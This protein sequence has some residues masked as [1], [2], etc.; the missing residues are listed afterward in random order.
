MRRLTYADIDAAR[1]TRGQTVLLFLTDRCPVGC[2][3]C[4]VDSR[5]DS[6]KIRDFAR[7]EEVIDG[8]CASSYGL[9]GISGGEPFI[10]R[11]GL[12]H[13]TARLRAAGKDISIVT[14]GVWATTDDPPGWITEVLGRCGCVVLSTDIFHSDALPDERFVHA[15]RTIARAGVWVVTQV[16]EDPEAE[17]HAVDMLT[18]A[19][20]TGWTEYAEIRSA[21]LL[22]YGRAA[23]L[24]QPTA[25]TE[26][27]DF[28]PC[29]L[30]RSPVIR[31][32]GTMSVCCNEAVI[33]G[34]GPES[35]RRAC[36][37]ADDLGEAFA[38]L[39]R[40]ALFRAI[41]DAGPGVLTLD[42]RLSDMADRGY[43]SICEMCWEMAERV[44][45]A[46]DDPIFRAT[47][48]L[49]AETP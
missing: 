41:A 45:D 34:R 27:R 6:P 11:R 43:R 35:L 40:H 14:S 23:D 3:H 37:T 24:F 15:A 39:D 5:P 36:T 29:Y 49:T 10:E 7:F 16:I 20:G 42:P 33:M 47:S 46:A 22:P 8:L 12:S 30:A 32:D 44:G 21:P 28:G 9:V 25:T 31:Y 4:S 13:A 18:R 26:G 17:R 48:R 19:F 38:D 1:H 2:A